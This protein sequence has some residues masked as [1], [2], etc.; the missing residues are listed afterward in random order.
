MQQIKGRG[1]SNKRGLVSDINITPFV[2]VLL[3]LLII[4]MVTTPMMNGAIDVELPNGDSSQ[5]AVSQQSLC[6][7]IDKNGDVFIEDQPIKFDELSK[8]LIE[9]SEGDLKKPILV[10]ADKKIDYGKVMEVVKIIGQSGFK[11]VEL[12]TEIVS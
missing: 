2:D 7:F 12:V 3:V 5:A 4:F 1:N 8:N 11:R 9:V 6:V 10:K